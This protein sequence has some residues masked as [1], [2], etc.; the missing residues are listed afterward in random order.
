MLL[1]IIVVKIKKSQKKKITIKFDYFVFANV[2]KKVFCMSNQVIKRVG[3]SCA[4]VEVV[5]TPS[6]VGLLQTT[7]QCHLI[8]TA[9]ATEI[10][11]S[12]TH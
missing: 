2:K 5:T 6:V 10:A 12:L 8:V 11:A 7:S 3:Y 9:A 4:V 1:P